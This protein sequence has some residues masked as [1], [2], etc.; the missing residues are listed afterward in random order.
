MTTRPI[1]HVI[2][3][4]NGAGKS[5]LYE[6]TLSRMIGAEFINA[7]LLAQAEIGRYATTRAEAERGQH[8]ANERRAALMAEGKSLIT[9]STF[10]HESKLVLIRDAQELGY[11]V[12]VYHVSLD[13]ADLAV[14]RVAARYRSGGHPVPEDNIRGRFER[15]R[16]FIREAML[17]AQA[18]FV[19]D[20]SI[21]GEAPRRL[22]TFS[23]GRPV[24]VA[25][26]LPAWIAEVYGVELA[27]WRQV[28]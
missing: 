20:N 23:E 12:I 13:T 25:A 26:D 3:G 15:N 2:A 17:M 14:A 16:A 11:D 18:G 1:L 4:P 8:L 6:A 5:S 9:E 7:D 10:S 28:G 19:F 27:A 21:L 24:A 22:I